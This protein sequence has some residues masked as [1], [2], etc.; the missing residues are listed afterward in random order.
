MT[1]KEKK[2]ELMRYIDGIKEKPILTNFPKKKRIGEPKQIL[3]CDP[4]EVIIQGKLF[5]IYFY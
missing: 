3:F 4:E 5:K 1:E 2:A